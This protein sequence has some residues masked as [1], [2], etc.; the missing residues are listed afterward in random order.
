MVFGL[1]VK[2]FKRLFAAERTAPGT[3]SHPHPILADALKGDEA[4]L[5][6]GRDG[7]DE[8]LFKVLRIVGAKIV[9]AVVDEPFLLHSEDCP[10]GADRFGQAQFALARDTLGE[11]NWDFGEFRAGEVESE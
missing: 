9:E 1:Q 4:A 11:G 5:H 3:R 7:V 10:T 8:Q 2:F 6:H